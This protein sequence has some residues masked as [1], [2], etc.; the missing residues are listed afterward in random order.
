MPWLRAGRRFH[1]LAIEFGLLS[2]DG[3]SEKSNRERNELEIKLGKLG[4]AVPWSK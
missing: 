4:F 1:Q 3:P 2:E